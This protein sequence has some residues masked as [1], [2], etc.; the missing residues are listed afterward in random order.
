MKRQMCTLLAVGL[1]SLALAQLSWLNPRQEF[2]ATPTDLEIHASY[3]FTNSGK[4]AVIISEVKPTCGCTTANLAKQEYQPGEGGV[5]ETTFKIGNRKGRQNKAIRVKTDD[6]SFPER[7]LMLIVDIPVLLTIKP[8]LLYWRVGEP[9]TPK[10][11]KI[12]SGSDEWEVTQVKSSAPAFTAEFETIN[13][14][15]YQVSVTPNELSQPLNTRLVITASN[16][17]GKVRQL[18]AYL[19]VLG[20]PK[21]RKTP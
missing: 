12:T 5:I 3:I 16:K 2:T 6:Q 17:A 15:E 1:P 20:V 8:Q 18:Q 19:R 21:P 7:K 9:K 4:Y 10:W 11:I 13:P 14:G